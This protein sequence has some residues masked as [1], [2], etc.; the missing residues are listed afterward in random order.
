MKLGGFLEGILD[1]KRELEEL[2]GLLGDFFESFSDFKREFRGLNGL[3]T[4]FLKKLTTN[5][6]KRT[7]M[8]EKRFTTH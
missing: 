6:H 4:Y 5:P 7:R 2:N 1:F 3:I 8:E